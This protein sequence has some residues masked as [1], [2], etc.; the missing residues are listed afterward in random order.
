[1]TRTEDSVLTPRADVTGTPPHISAHRPGRLVR[2]AI[3]LGW[4]LISV[5]SATLGVVGFAAQR[6][7]WSLS[8]CLSPGQCPPRGDP[9]GPEFLIVGAVIAMPALLL[10]FLVGLAPTRR[11]YSISLGAGVLLLI[12]FIAIHSQADHLV[13]LPDLLAA[14]IQQPLEALVFVLGQFPDLL[15]ALAMVLA[16]AAARRSAS[17]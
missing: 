16:S 14:F 9:P 15:V 8:E 6:L 13:P 2:A 17:T 1:M 11:T 12:S 3:L 4:L 5:G 7:A 10:V